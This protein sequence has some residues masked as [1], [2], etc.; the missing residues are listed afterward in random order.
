[1]I[2]VE[3]VCDGCNFNPF[4]EEYR[5]TSVSR[6]KKKAKE[7]GWKTIDGKIYCPECKEKMRRYRMTLD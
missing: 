5:S 2:W 7:A 3:I 6:I 4:G 1:M